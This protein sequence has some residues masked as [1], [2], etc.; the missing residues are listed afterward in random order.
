[1]TEFICQR[2][3]QCCGLA[4]FTRSEYKAVWRTAKNMGITL[5]K[6]NIEGQQYYLPRAL[7]RLFEIPPEKVD[8][9][10]ISCPFLGQDK[11]KKFYCR[12]Y[13]LRPEICRLFGTHPEDSPRLVCPQQKNQLNN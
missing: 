11:E 1:M 10:K 12:I 6:I 2:C 9:E 8:P 13:E 5:V 7:A 3:G 4:P